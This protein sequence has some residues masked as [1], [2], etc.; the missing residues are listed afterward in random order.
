MPYVAG[1][2][3]ATRGNP[4]PVPDAIRIAT[5]IAGA[6]DYI[7]RRADH[8]DIADNV[9]FQMVEPWWLISA[10]RYLSQSDDEPADSAGHGFGHAVLHESRAGRRETRPDPRT[11]IFALGVVLYEMLAG[12]PIHRRSIQ[13][14]FGQ[15][16]SDEAAPPIHS[17]RLPHH[18]V[19]TRRARSRSPRRP[20]AVRRAILRCVGR[21]YPGERHGRSRRHPRWADPRFPGRLDRPPA[22]SVWPPVGEG[23]LIPGLM[24]FDTELDPNRT[25]LHAHR[26]SAPTA[27]SCS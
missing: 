7:Y 20:L 27:D 11:D 10:S 24:R 4:L 6:L 13:E 1:G 19:A 14:I 15:I 18:V 3:P 16:L 8:R 5:E 22:R 17:R 12:C 25:H 23:A 9:L 26:D 21:S 2:S